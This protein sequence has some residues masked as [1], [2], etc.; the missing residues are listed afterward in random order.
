MLS[1]A[2]RETLEKYYSFTNSGDFASALKFFADDAVY[3]LPPA[4]SRV[5]YAG[6]WT[7]KSGVADVYSAFGDAF[8]L[9]DMI[10]LATV[11]SENELVSINDEI[12]V[13]KSGHP[14]RVGVA[15]QFTFR[16]G[17]ITS[18]DVHLDLGAAHEV[19]SGRPC[20]QSALLPLTS[21]PAKDGS[22]T[23]KTSSVAS[24][25]ALGNWENL[26]NDAAIYVPGDPRRLR[27]AGSWPGQNGITEFRAQWS[28]AFAGDYK[29]ERILCEGSNAFL[30]GHLKGTFLPT[31]KPIDQPLCKFVQVNGQGK[32]LRDFWYLNTYP[33][34]S[35]G[36]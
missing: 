9:V 29:I 20:P 33:F 4:S 19:L 35:L 12:F 27:F 28:K 17:L 2:N 3:R 14:W 1:T 32:V 36:D 31:N 6:S 22:D 18:L 26:A 23:S 7:G 15:H 25:Y 24:S 13:A 30:L 21:S 16:D 34:V 11:S 8:A 10:E 5:L